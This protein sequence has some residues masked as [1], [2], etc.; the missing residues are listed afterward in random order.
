MVNSYVALGDSFTAGNGIGADRRWADLLAAGLADGREDFEYLNLA[1]DGADSNEVLATIGKAIERQPDLVTLICGANDVLLSTR[2]D[3]D[4]FEGRFDYMLQRLRNDVPGVRILVSTYPDGWAMPGL[5]PRTARRID[6]G[7]KAVNRAIIEIAF[8][9]G[10]PCLDVTSHPDARKP[11]NLDSDGL[12]PSARGH[13]Q[14]AREY[15]EALERHFQI[16][17]NDRRITT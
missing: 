11:G 13:R 8:A 7:I 12:H 3:V 6:R 5:G 10:V 1:R 15:G 9:H 16:N 4:G 2:P 14:A 17:T